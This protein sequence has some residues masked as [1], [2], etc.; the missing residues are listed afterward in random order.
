MGPL[1][2][3]SAAAIAAAISCWLSLLE[4][5]YRMGRSAWLMTSSDRSFI[6]WLICLQCSEVLQAEMIGPEISSQAVFMIKSQ[7]ASQDQS[8]KAREHPT[9]FVLKLRYKIVHGVF[10]GVDLCLGT[11]NNPTSGKRRYFWLRL[12]CPEGQAFSLPLRFGS[13]NR[14]SSLTGSVKQGRWECMNEFLRVLP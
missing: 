5:K 9:E 12:R 11:T 14:A 3:P 8:I 6:S 1:S 2:M 10:S 7:R 13:S 4:F